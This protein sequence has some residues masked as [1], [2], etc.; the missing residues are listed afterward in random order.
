MSDAIQRIK[1]LQRRYADKRQ[2]AVADEDDVGAAY[3]SGQVS[4]LIAAEEA[5]KDSV[6]DD[7]E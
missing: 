6:E 5:I 2:D 7:H 1:E 4:G 3:F